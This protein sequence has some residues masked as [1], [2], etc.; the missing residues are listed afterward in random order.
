M[1]V[2]LEEELVVEAGFREEIDE[3]EGIVSLNLLTI[4]CKCFGC[5]N[6]LL[7]FVVL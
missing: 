5:C 3:N 6:D 2:D 7:V 1:E 4:V